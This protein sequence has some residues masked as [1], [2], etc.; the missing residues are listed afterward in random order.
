MFAEMDSAFERTELLIGEERLERL[1][2]AHV[3]VVGLGGV[4]AYAAEMLCRAGV[5]KL[6][7]LDADR[8][9]RSNR[10]RQLIALC[11]TE[12]R[13]KTEVL[14]ERLRDINKNVSLVP[15]SEY[16]KEEKVGEILEAAHYDYV[17]DAIDT[18]RPKLFLTAGCVK[19]GI[20]LVSSM[21]SGGKMNPS[22]IQVADISQSFNCPLA[23]MLRKKLHKFGIYD[24]FAVV[25]S[26]E[27]IPEGSVREER[28]ENKRTNVGTISYMPAIFGCFAASVVIREL[29]GVSAYKKV[30]DKRYYHNKKTSVCDFEEQIKQTENVKSREDGRNV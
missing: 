26:P 17:V 8:V 21:G 19:R 20:P 12:G 24:G 15:I 29:T 22:L 2:S 28:S 6:T 25:F 3:L 10:N 23:R 9:S 14:A 13:L 16:L 18:L 27:D 7:L 11:S 4:G 30:K 5:G 1:H